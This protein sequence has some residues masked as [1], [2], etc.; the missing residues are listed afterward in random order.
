MSKLAKQ[1]TKVVLTG[2]GGD[3]V[4]GGYSNW[5]SP[6]YWL[7]TLDKLSL[8]K[9]ILE[10]C[11]LMIK[12]GL[13]KNR[14]YLYKYRG[15]GFKKKDLSIDIAHKTQNTY[16]SNKE[17]DSLL[18]NK[19]QNIISAEDTWVKNNSLDDAMRMDIENYM[20]GDILTK[21][22]KASMAN[23]LE[24]RAPFLDVDFASFCISLP[25]CLKVTKETDKLILRK[26]F[27]KDWP[28][29][30]R[31]RGKQGFGA[32]IKKW[33]SYPEMKELIKKYLKN[34]NNRIFEIISFEN[35]QSFVNKNNYQTWVLLVLSI[36]MEKH[37]F[38][39]QSNL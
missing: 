27:S 1:Y 9:Y 11:V 34:P 37:D 39:I 2:D 26:A 35:T 14:K 15:L 17:L 28:E 38:L 10:S 23:G 29:S 24:L 31:K 30:I 33:L 3:E 22:D 12:L 21:I 4:C 6:L 19:T 25:H 5:Y 18:K 16:F 32:P 20:P 7:Q 8:K 36:W 13:T